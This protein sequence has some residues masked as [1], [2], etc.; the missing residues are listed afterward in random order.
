MSGS[1]VFPPNNSTATGTINASYDKVSHTLS[2]K[3]SWAGLSTPPVA[4]H[5]H[6]VADPGFLALPAPLGPFGTD[7]IRVAPNTYVKYIGGIAQKITP[8]KNAKTTDSYSG[9]LFADGYVIKE[10]DILNGK[11]YIDIHSAVSP[12]IAT[13][14]IRGQ[15]TFNQ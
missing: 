5:V 1:Q 7:S 4:I 8:D 10:E 13:G 15:I 11:Y 14:E 2:Y 3:I 6:G 12:Y 9:S